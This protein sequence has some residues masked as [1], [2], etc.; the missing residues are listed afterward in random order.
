MIVTGAFIVIDVVVVLLSFF[1]PTQKNKRQHRT[2]CTALG[3]TRRT[4]VLNTPSASPW[5]GWELLLL[6]VLEKKPTTHTD[7]N[8]ISFRLVCSN[9]I[10]TT[11]C[12]FEVEIVAG[13]FFFEPIANGSLDTRS[14]H[15]HTTPKQKKGMMCLLVVN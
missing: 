13:G 1:V 15:T 9:E 2:R 4:S 6:L 14:S 8:H 12:L 3:S 7:A 5:L 11:E 10:D